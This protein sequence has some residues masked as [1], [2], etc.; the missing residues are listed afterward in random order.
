MPPHGFS[1]AKG[2]KMQNRKYPSIRL[3]LLTSL[4]TCAIFTGCPDGKLPENGPS[5]SP[6]PGIVSVSAQSGELM[7]GYTGQAQYDVSTQSIPNGTI[8]SIKWFSDVSGTISVDRPMGITDI[9]PPTRDQ[10]TQV[11][12]LSDTA[13]TLNGVYYYRLLESDAASSVKTL[14]IDPT[15]QRS[16]PASKVYVGGQ[17]VMVTDYANGQLLGRECA[18]YW[19]DGIWHRFASP[20]PYGLGGDPDRLVGLAISGTDVYASGYCTDCRGNGY[21]VIPGFWTN[22]IWNALDNPYGTSNAC[23]GSMYILGDDI[24]ICGYVYPSNPQAILPSPSYAGYWRNATWT[25][26]KNPY[27]TTD[28]PPHQAIAHSL[29]VSDSS[30]YAVGSCFDG[31]RD[32]AG[33][34]KD[35]TWNELACP[36]QDGGCRAYDI[37]MRGADIYVGGMANSYGKIGNEGNYNAVCWENGLCKTLVEP[38]LEENSWV[39][40]LL[41]VGTDVY[42]SVNRR[43][44]DQ[45]NRAYKRGYFKN[46]VWTDLSDPH[47]GG[48]WTSEIAVW[49]SDVYISGCSDI[50]SGFVQSSTAGYWKNGVWTE[51]SD[52]QAPTGHVIRASMIYVFE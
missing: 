50:R 1:P 43:K 8:G 48:A 12:M 15:Q 32:H 21:K 20:Y 34:W 6:N 4:L 47:Q 14:T 25:E 26:L 37:A 19:G 49:G 9:I 30:V 39:S 16:Y 3:T 13:T 18:G 2:G 29:V 45:S 35:G 44:T 33:F 51:L 22:G 41:A 17:N 38:S 36:Y 31:T 10:T 46:L 7:Q 52:P 11:V 28:S 24:Y 5:E 40:S 27:V 23:V 42:I